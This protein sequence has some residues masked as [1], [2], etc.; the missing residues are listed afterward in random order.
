M[1]VMK[2]LEVRQQVDGES[3]RD[4]I[5]ERIRQLEQEMAQ[6]SDFEDALKCADFQGEENDE[7]D[8]ENQESDAD[9]ELRTYTKEQAKS[10]N[11]YDNVEEQS[12]SDL[13]DEEL[14]E[15]SRSGLIHSSR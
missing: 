1:G 13:G 11:V 14:S 15:L 6:E 2:N 4:R 5:R 9:D 7:Y 3:Q 12:C 8:P 10:H